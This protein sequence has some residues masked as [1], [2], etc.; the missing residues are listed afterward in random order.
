MFKYDIY[1]DIDLILSNNLF[2]LNYPSC[3]NILCVE[4]LPDMTPLLPLMNIW[5]DKGTKRESTEELIDALRH[6]F[7]VK[8]MNKICYIRNIDL[9]IKYYCQKYP[10]VLELLKLVMKCVLLGNLP[11]SKNPLDLKSRFFI[12]LMFDNEYSNYIFNNEEESNNILK[13]QL[14]INNKFFLWIKKF[15]YC[16]LFILREFLFYTVEISLI[17]DNILDRNYKW[18]SFKKLSRYALGDIRKEISDQIKNSNFK[19][20]N[21]NK[22]ELRTKNKNKFNNSIEKKTGK[23]KGYHTQCLLDSEKLKKAEFD[24]IILKKM[25]AIEPLLD[26]S[27]LYNLVNDEQ[28]KYQTSFLP[29]NSPLFINNKRIFNYNENNK[30]NNFYLNFEN[31]HFLCWCIAKR[32]KPILETIW[33]KLLNISDNGFETIKSWIFAYYEFSIPDNSFK[34]Y[35]IK[36]YNENPLDYLILK[37][38]IKTIEFYKNES[39]FYLPLEDT[40]YQ[41]DSLRK[42]L[43][44]ESWNYTPKKSGFGLL[45]LGCH[46]WAN[47]I[48]EPYSKIINKKRKLI[49]KK[50]QKK[51]QKL[52]PIIIINKDIESSSSSENEIEKIINE[53]EEG[54]NLEKLLKETDLKLFSKKNK[55]KISRNGYATYLSN[56]LLDPE[57]TTDEGCLYCKRGIYIRDYTVVDKSELQIKKRND[58]RFLYKN[59][60]SNLFKGFYKEEIPYDDHNNIYDMKIDFNDYNNNDL[61]MIEENYEDINLNNNINNNDD[62]DDNNTNNNNMIEEELFDPELLLGINDLQFISENPQKFEKSF[63]NIKIP[64]LIIKKNNNDDSLILYGYINKNNNFEEYDEKGYP[65]E[66]DILIKH[67]LTK[68]SY[69]NYSFKTLNPNDLLQIE[70]GDYIK[71]KK[72]NQL[73]GNKLF[74]NKE[75]SKSN[76]LLINKNLTITGIINHIVNTKYNCYNQLNE[77]DLV[78]I[79]YFYKN[80][81]YTLCSYCGCFIKVCNKNFSNRGFTCGRHATTSHNFDNLIWQYDREIPKSISHYYNLKSKC[82]LSRK[83]EKT[84]ILNNNIKDL[85]KS[86]QIFK[87]RRL[88]HMFDYRDITPKLHYHH[89]SW[90]YFC[91]NVE[92]LIYITIRNFVFKIIKIPLCK[93][94]AQHCYKYKFIKKSIISLSDLELW[95]KSM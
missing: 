76:K 88:I 91:K 4:E 16:I 21:W 46:R 2:L 69:G 93:N 66:N 41:F 29:D 63:Q 35:A 51:Q 78:G 83:D 72:I 82:I 18:R 62:D 57:K 68:N 70:N 3:F 37:S 81:N 14:S 24:K 52:D 87:N 77:I 15:K 28:F 85:S 5:Y 61:M 7:M 6:I 55:S 75:L 49:I 12:N 47:K 60:I 95:L 33:L 53:E 80:T 34:E 92:S 26:I 40:I 86:K 67:K 90:C 89:D 56:A 45:C 74:Y 54:E 38:Y 44:L 9:M 23:L 27:R 65:I 73:K 11:Y 32:N 48:T 71:I 13:Q 42:S 22:I 17:V 79:I 19:F 1:N 50:K 58:S 64:N 10:I 8:P 43:R 39:I 59:N 20:I 36:L 31:F 25:R 30:E 94:H 84:I